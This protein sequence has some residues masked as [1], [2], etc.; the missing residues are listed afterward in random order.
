MGSFSWTNYWLQLVWI[1][2]G[3]FLLAFLIPKREEIVLEKHQLRWHPIAAILLVVPYIL[4]AGFRVRG[5]GDTGLYMASFNRFPSSISSIPNYLSTISKD[6]GYPVLA[7]VFKSIFGN[8]QV[9]FFLFIATIQ[10]IIIALIYRKYSED[11]WL[12]IFVFIASTDYMSWM[13]NGMRQFLAVTIIFAA[14]PLILKKKYVWA[15][16]LILLA[17]TFHLSALLMIPIFLIA[18]GKAWNWRT[19][20][21]LAAAI[22]VLF[23]V[24]RFTG[25]LDTLLSD[26]QYSNVVS[27]WTDWEDNG[28]NP[29]RVLIYSIPTILSF[30]G[31][32]YVHEEGDALINMSVGLS[33]CST[34]IYLVSMVTSG[35]FVGRI[36]IY[37]S[38]YATGILLPWMIDHMFTD[39][40]RRLVK[41][42]AVVLYTAFFYYQMHIQWKIM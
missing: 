15:L 4:W 3:G 9:L 23:F 7:I 39:N 6:K 37:M 31:L 41:V 29:V 5:Y 12:S 8:R 20:V 14:T 28:T 16:M 30:I 1:F 35:I 17:A 36:P 13:H 19:W 21:L 22:A 34:A 11:Y 10:L 33:I 25:L 27:D 26:T 32:R 18:Q 42:A 2:I 38:L 24:D 40:S